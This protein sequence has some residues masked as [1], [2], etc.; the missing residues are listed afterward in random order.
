M[1]TGSDDKQD[2]LA[3][4]SVFTKIIEITFLLPFFHWVCRY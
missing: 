2:L 4:S 1:G 3:S